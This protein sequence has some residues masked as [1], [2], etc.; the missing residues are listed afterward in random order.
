MESEVQIGRARRGLCHEGGLKYDRR[1]DVRKEGKLDKKI[2]K[3][4]LKVGFGLR[5]T[6]KERSSQ[7][8]R[9]GSMFKGE[10][11]AQLRN[12]QKETGTRREEICRLWTRSE[13]HDVVGDRRNTG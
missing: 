12:G 2:R 7:R 11:G 4:Y 13:I 5:G 8:A 1:S 9:E 10:E 6:W 3:E